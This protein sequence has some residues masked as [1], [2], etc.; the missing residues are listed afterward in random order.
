M[1]PLDGIGLLVVAALVVVVVITF[2]PGNVDARPIE[3]S[4]T[5]DPDTIAYGFG[6]ENDKALAQALESF[7]GPHETPKLPEDDTDWEGL[8]IT[9]AEIAKGRDQF[10]KSCLH[11]HGVTGDASGSTAEF[12]NPKP[13]NFRRGILKFTST[14]SRFPGV[15]EDIMRILHNGVAYTAMPGFAAYPEDVIDKEA[16]AA[17]VMFLGI[18][19]RTESNTAFMLE[20][21]G[22]FEEDYEGEELREEILSLMTDEYEAIMETW[23]EA[24]DELIEPPIERPEPTPASLARGK[25]VFLSAR[26]ECSACHGDDG[27]G[28]GPNVYDAETGTFKLEDI[29]G[30]PA[31]PADLRKGF[32]RGGNR[33]IDLYRRIAGG[34]KGTPMPS[35]VDSLTPEQIW[36]VVNYVYALPYLDEP[37]EAAH[38]LEGGM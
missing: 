10:R 25:E 34:I 36:D 2:S 27:S 15:K 20:D 18:R 5:L 9:Q 26:T 16:L 6:P 24:R 7:F 11:C 8:A 28:R 21:E 32:Y 37:V 38:E 4:Y 14:P 13:R 22:T 33:P 29:W 17:Y 3:L 23:V 35:F 19:G 12:V 31:Q 30:N 1:K